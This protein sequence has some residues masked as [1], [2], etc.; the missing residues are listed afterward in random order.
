MTDYMHMEAGPEMDKAAL[1]VVLGW[2]LVDVD[3]EI[4]NRPGD[5]FYEDEKHRIE[6]GELVPFPDGESLGTPSQVKYAAELDSA[7][8]DAVGLYW[9]RGPRD[10][11]EFGEFCPPTDPA[12]DY[13]V[14]VHV[15]GTWD[16]PDKACFAECL[17]RIFLARD[18][19]PCLPR[20]H[21]G[22]E[23]MIEFLQPGDY[24]RAALMAAQEKN[25]ER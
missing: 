11:V 19:E 3:Y 13:E 8:V 1:T 5:P 15:R 20:E 17:Q 7:G 22:F 21:I 9:R 12:A 6:S 18:P 2:E 14:L 23:E 16:E 4:L 25:D 24:S 10:F